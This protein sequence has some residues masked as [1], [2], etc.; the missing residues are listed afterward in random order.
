MIYFKNGFVR[1]NYGL[2]LILARWPVRE[3]ILSELDFQW[4]VYIHHCK[5]AEMKIS[6]SE[7][8][9]S[10]NKLQTDTVQALGNYCFP[11]VATWGT[12][13]KRKNSQNN[14][15]SHAWNLT[16]GGAFKVDA[17]WCRFYRTWQHKLAKIRLDKTLEKL[18]QLSLNQDWHPSA[19]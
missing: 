5:E 15:A 10:W 9:M 2:V 4:I 1:S 3:N 18:V 16:F 13:V 6:K 11:S 17:S 14:L 12:A 19:M 8:W 7:S